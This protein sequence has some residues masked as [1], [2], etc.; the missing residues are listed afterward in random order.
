MSRQTVKGYIFAILSAVLFGC[1]PLMAKHIYADGVNPFTLVFLRNLF[2]LIPLGL[3]AYRE[4]KTLVIPIR[5]LPAI[6]L[7][8]AL[9]C[10]A[11]P[12]L[13]FCSYKFIASGTATV[14][15][16]VYPAFVILG[17]LVFLRKKLRIGSL[18][19]VALCVA[20]VSL[21]Y[22]PG[23][24]LNL[25]GSLLALI[26]GATF[27]GYVILLSCFGKH[28]ISGLL[29]TFYIVLSSTVITCLVC[30]VSGS[31][32]FP[33]TGKG[34]GLCVLFSLLVTVGAVVLFQQAT[35][36]IGGQRVSILSTLEP[37]T[38]VVIGVMVL[39]EAM[40]TRTVAGVALVLAASL[41]TA[42][43]DIKKKPDEGF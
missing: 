20:G 11:T 6:G 10:C 34:W 9:G 19:S 13:L 36:L 21:F 7:I 12:I 37:I 25:T 3:L 18:V 32:A 29:L 27:A 33:A 40:G 1:M 43:L 30:L 31:F 38:G 2:A 14:M 17:E 24:A 22:A 23:E 4:A 16:F 15:H 42:I 28:R 26:S 8:A 41:L 35:F 39:H 5:R